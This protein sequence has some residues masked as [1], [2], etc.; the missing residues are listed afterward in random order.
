MTGFDDSFTLNDTEI[1]PALGQWFQQAFPDLGPSV[2][3]L[4]ERR[5]DLGISS[6]F[7]VDQVI[8][9]PRMKSRPVVP[10]V[11][12]EGA[13]SGLI[14][15]RYHL[16]QGAAAGARGRASS[17]T[18]ENA[19]EQQDNP[20]LN[21]CPNLPKDFGRGM[22][23]SATDASL[24]K[25]YTVAFC[26]GRTLLAESNGFLN[27]ITPMAA[28]NHCVKH[29]LLA[30]SATYV[31]DYLPSKELERVANMHHKRAVILLSQAL[32]NEKTY[33]PGGE[34]AVLVNWET[35]RERS[36]TPEWLTRN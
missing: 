25:F 4:A 2:P 24:L 3:V 22:K 23:L 16:K 8:L 10:R 19:N 5:L 32:N 21:P 9:H 12:S 33:I 30:L 6:P 36:K 31:L 17:G 7:A 14:K 28:S 20:F 35:D 11:R 34:D 27:D 26:S 15:F 1:S 29:A 18:T 13:V